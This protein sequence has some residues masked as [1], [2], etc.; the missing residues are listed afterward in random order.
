MRG[1]GLQSE[2]ES[3]GLVVLHAFSRY[4]CMFFKSPRPIRVGALTKRSFKSSL[5]ASAPK[6]YWF[7]PTATS[8]EEK[9]SRRLWPEVYGESVWRELAEV[10]PYGRLCGGWRTNRRRLTTTRKRTSEC[11]RR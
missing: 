8:S 3:Q 2:T 11:Q 9:G 6:V 1:T 4:R 5:R 10:D 7:C